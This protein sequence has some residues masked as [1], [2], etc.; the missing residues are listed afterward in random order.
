MTAM[1]RPINRTEACLRHESLQRKN[2]EAELVRINPRK[3]SIEAGIDYPVLE[4]ITKLLE[5][6][7]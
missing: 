6:R 5:K 1:P 3:K 4:L 7:K 2:R